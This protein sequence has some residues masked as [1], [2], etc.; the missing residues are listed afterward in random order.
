[1]LV[2]LLHKVTGSSFVNKSTPADCT[3]VIL[4]AA[5]QEFEDVEMS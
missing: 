4:Q 2:R 1:M 3:D 5:K